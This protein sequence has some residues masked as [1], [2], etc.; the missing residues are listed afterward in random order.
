MR[1]WL[2]GGWIPAITSIAIFAGTA[3]AQRVA[4]PGDDAIM[5]PRGA[6]RFSATS[7]WSSFDQRFGAGTPATGA[8]G[9]QPLGSDF[10]V[11]SIGVR[12]LPGLT[13]LQS[14]LRGLAGD[15]EWNPTLGN[16]LLS[17]RDRVSTFTFRVEA[18]LVR[19]LSIGVDVPYVVT[20]A[21]PFFNVN[22]SGTEG[23]I[24][25]NPALTNTAAAAQNATLLSQFTASAASLAQKLSDCAA[26]PGA[27]GCPE[28]NA[29]RASAQSLI[30]NSTAF[31]TGV[32]T[33][34][35]A[36]PFV[37]I[38]G[39]D[40]QLAIEARVA[41]FKALYAQ[42]AGFGVPQI[43]SSGPFA[44]QN[45]ITVTDAQQI[46][47]DPAFGISA[48]PLTTTSRSHFGD[49]AIGGK[50]SLFDSF[51]GSTEERM[52]PHGLNFRTAIGGAFELP[53]GQVESPNN[54]I[55]VGTGGTKAIEGRWFADLLIGSHFWESFVVR[56]NK[57]FAD[58]Q[59]MRIVDVPGTEFAPLYSRQTV[60]RALGR[61]IQFETSPRLVINDFFSVGGQYVYRHKA[62]DQYTGTF[63]IPAAVTG[64]SEVTLDATALGMDTETKEQRASGGLTY[65]NLYAF[66]Q[67]RAKLPFEVTY[68]HSQT[69][70]GSGR[71]QPKSFSDA[72]QLR[73]YFP[74]FGRR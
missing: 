46:L 40:A 35:G 38:R 14:E 47:S 57:P 53:T 41:A 30:D 25:F 33:V 1:R 43:T 36:S 20:R 70:S 52:S 34:Y 16:S 22:T 21:N 10:T 51:G 24:G 29:Q 7:D 8:S 55:D 4:G 67:G 65:S 56:V 42:F 74:V 59:E 32:N 69:I 9:L 73:V 62:Q 3:R 17:L 26:N 66:E 11:D 15:P 18:G 60:H 13:G 39:T 27:A 28:L 19:R 37:P 6:I 12:Q 63:T 2:A 71:T 31:A 5:V 50:L 68:L 48:D 44:S 23:N 64:F 45:R 61:T 72:I 54:F 49:I 58:D